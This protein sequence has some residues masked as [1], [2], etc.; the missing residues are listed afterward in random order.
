MYTAVVSDN[1]HSNEG[2]GMGYMFLWTFTCEIYF[3]YQSFLELWI[4]AELIF[5]AWND[6]R[7][8]LNII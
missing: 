8:I 1:L 5:Y 4:D 3:M 7:Y 2:M 6:P